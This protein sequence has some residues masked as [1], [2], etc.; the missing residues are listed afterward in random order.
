AFGGF[1]GVLVS[2]F[3]LLLCLVNIIGSGVFVVLVG[4]VCGGGRRGMHAAGVA[5]SLGVRAQV[6]FDA[7]PKKSPAALE[8]I[9]RVAGMSI[10][11]TRAELGKLAL[12]AL[13]ER[14]A[15]LWVK[16]V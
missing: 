3:G 11:V 15:G 1:F 12:K 9:A 16:S 8:S 2:G 14:R 5:P 13:V 7:V 4:G 10:E 6:V